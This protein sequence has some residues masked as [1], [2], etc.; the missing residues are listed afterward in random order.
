MTEAVFETT[1][2]MAKFEDF[3]DRAG[4]MMYQTD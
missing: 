2:E 3:Q 4:K 1:P